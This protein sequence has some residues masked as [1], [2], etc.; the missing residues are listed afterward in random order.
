MLVVSREREKEI[1][2]YDRVAGLDH[3]SSPYRI[4]SYEHSCIPSLATSDKMWGLL[5]I[6]LNLTTSLYKSGPLLLKLPDTSTDML[7]C[8]NSCVWGVT[9]LNLQL[10]VIKQRVGGDKARVNM[11]PAWEAK[12]WMFSSPR[13]NHN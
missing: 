3:F 4:H 9:A 5:G 2:S 8:K 12:M 10:F 1:E 6:G 13:E 7:L 11:L